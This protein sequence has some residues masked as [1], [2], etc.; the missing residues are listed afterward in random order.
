MGTK[1]GPNK[2]TAIYRVKGSPHVTYKLIG[3]EQTQDHLPVTMQEDNLGGVV[4]SSMVLS[5]QCS[6]AVK[7]TLKRVENKPENT[8]MSLSAL[9]LFLHLSTLC[10]SGPLISNRV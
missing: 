5:A 2:C 9:W 6:L 10:S 1:F 4:D 7:R 8:A 3:C